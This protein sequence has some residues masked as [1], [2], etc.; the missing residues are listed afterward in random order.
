LV[1][2]NGMVLE[3]AAGMALASVPLPRPGRLAALLLAIACVLLL[4][5]PQ[6]GPWRFLVW[7]LPAAAVLAAALVLEASLGAEI[8]A[9]MLAVGDASYAIYLIHPF[10]VPALAALG[11]TAAVL[12]VLVSVVAGLLL[13]RQVD[14]RLQHALGKGRRSAAAVVSAAQRASPVPF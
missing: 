14:A 6:A 4:I 11:P 12:S 1:L 9:A 13:H 8:P 5:L 10:V 3:F 7:G 2:A